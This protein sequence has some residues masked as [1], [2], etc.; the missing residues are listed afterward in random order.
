MGCRELGEGFKARANK[1]DHWDSRTE[2]S[3]GGK[4]TNSDEKYLSKT[5]AARDIG[6]GWGGRSEKKIRDMNGKSFSKTPR[7]PTPG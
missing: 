4:E 1:Q 5:K 7:S 3:F 2:H 6:K